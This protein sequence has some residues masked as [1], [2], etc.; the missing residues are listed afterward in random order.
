MNE[1]DVVVNGGIG[2]TVPSTVIDC[3]Q[4]EPVLIRQ[5]AGEWKQ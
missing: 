2:S 5:G 4:E 3:T 1:V